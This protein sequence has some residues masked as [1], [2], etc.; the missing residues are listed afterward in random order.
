MKTALLALAAGE[1]R[2]HRRSI[3]TSTSTTRR[4]AP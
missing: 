1:T 2:R 3:I 4:S